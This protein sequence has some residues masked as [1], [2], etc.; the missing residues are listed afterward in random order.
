LGLGLLQIEELKI[1]RLDPCPL[2]MP[3]GWRMLLLFTGNC[4]GNVLVILVRIRDHVVRPSIPILRQM[5]QCRGMMPQGHG[6]AYDAYIWS[7]MTA[8]YTATSPINC[9]GHNI[10]YSVSIAGIKRK[11]SSSFWK[12]SLLGKLKKL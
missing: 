5:V 9:Y 7:Y 11:R 8:A 6:A 10:A 4:R 2:L 3:Y 12:R 1:L